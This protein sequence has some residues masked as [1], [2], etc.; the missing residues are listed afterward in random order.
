MF[1][2]EEINTEEITEQI[3]NSLSD[4]AADLAEIVVTIGA[5]AVAVKIFIDK[6]Q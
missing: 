1:F 6:I 5:A 2:M 4:L 3:Q